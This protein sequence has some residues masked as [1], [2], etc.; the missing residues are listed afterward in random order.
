L[1]Q[2]LND[3]LIAAPSAGN[4]RASP[5][6]TPSTVTSAAG[7]K[8]SAMR[9]NAETAQV[10]IT[11][12][13]TPMPS[14][15]YGDTVCVAGL[16]IDRGSPEWVRLYP[17]AFRWLDVAAQFR[18]YDI[19]EVEIRRRDGD[20]R[21]ES[22]SPT[23]DSIRVLD[24]LKDWKARQPIMGKVPRTSTCVLRAAAKRHD[25]PSLGMVPVARLVRV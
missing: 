21:P 10:L 25:A 8:L 15:K 4:W 5:L 17:I 18:K 1:T 22:F 3:S 2:V 13:T 23:E 7:S 14:T 6:A 11:V 20:S 19:V 24:H 16:R 9:I 12:K